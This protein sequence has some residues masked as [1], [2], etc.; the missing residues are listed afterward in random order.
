MTGSGPPV[1][2]RATSRL[3]LALGAAAVVIVVALVAAFLIVRKNP[4][5]AAPPPLSTIRFNGCAPAAADVH[6]TATKVT[7]GDPA[8]PGTTAPTSTAAPGTTSSS[9]SSS[10]STSSSPTSSPSSST[11]SSTS[12]T[13]STTP[14]GSAP[15]TTATIIGRTTTTFRPG[16]ITTP[17]GAE[18]VPLQP[19]AATRAATSD[20]AAAAI[21]RLA[22]PSAQ[23]VDVPLT[24]TGTTATFRIPDVDP[25]AAYT[26]A[27]QATGPCKGAI[28]RMH[29]GVAPNLGGTTF[30]K[31]AGNGMV[32]GGL[33]FA[34]DVDMTARA[35]VYAGAVDPIVLDG[36][37]RDNWRLMDT[38]PVKS[39]RTFHWASGASGT[40]KGRWQLSTAPMTKA[41]DAPSGLLAEGDAPFAA[42][43]LTDQKVDSDFKIDLDPYTQD[44]WDNV[45]DPEF[46]LNDPFN[47]GKGGS[48]TPTPTLPNGMPD[49]SKATGDPHPH[50]F[51]GTFY[52][53]V[54]PLKGD[55]TAD[56]AG[57]ASDQVTLLVGYPSAGQ[58]GQTALQVYAGASN[59]IGSADG[60]NVYYDSWVTADD[61]V[62]WDGTDS[63]SR[64]FR[65][66][67][68][69]PGTTT[70]EWQLSSQP[71]PIDCLDSPN[72]LAT[73]VAPFTPGPFPEKPAAMATFSIDF[74]TMAAD[75]AGKGTPMDVNIPYWLRV[76][77]HG[78]DPKT[79]TGDPSLAVRI[80][81]SNAPAPQY[82]PDNTPLPAPPSAPI[83]VKIASYQPF[84]DLNYN[85]GADQPFCFVALDAHDVS[86]DESFEGLLKVATEDAVG[87]FAVHGGHPS[88]HFQ[89]GEAFC[90][91][92]QPPEPSWWEEAFDFLV[93]VISF[94][95]KVYNL[96]L[97]IIP[98]ILGEILT[99]LGIP[100]SSGNAVNQSVPGGGN[101]NSGG[102]PSDC[103]KGLLFAE[104]AFLSAAGLPPSLPDA[105]QMLDDGEDYMVAE[106]AEN[107]GVDPGKAREA[108][109]QG[110]SAIKQQMAQKSAAQSG[111]TCS[112][113]ATD[114]GSRQPK[115]R[116]ELSRPADDQSGLPTP[117]RLCVRN[118]NP[119]DHVVYAP[120]C[121]WI[122]QL[123]PGQMVTVPIQL[124]PEFGSELKKARSNAY[125]DCYEGL[126]IS[127]HYAGCDDYA[128][129][130]MFQAWQGQH[131][132][133]EPTVAFLAETK[134]EYQKYPNGQ[135][136]SGAGNGSDYHTFDTT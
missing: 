6:L 23:P 66:T 26:V 17:P 54:L 105:Q 79:C 13:S 113:C 39:Q 7:F 34:I 22:T 44:V 83:S 64:M 76:V 28:V 68:T 30:A 128:D 109:D 90:F 3:P 103:F 120:S 67:S 101:D 78:D 96:Y 136:G 10:S 55:G 11:S 134:I 127:P 129:T 31:H 102:E 122:P 8:T 43:A 95:S 97:Q 104:K 27:L 38:V 108:W 118:A 2:A 21:A 56:C 58:T 100:C 20:E 114:N 131:F 106:I 12:T 72:L 98:A 125:S 61:H 29:A 45:V 74:K 57:P 107:A 50:P 89:Q 14:P 81:H 59:Y 135:T 121:V 33:P 32:I 119:P 42:G 112:W 15:S 60:P 53:R 77:P 19:I 82:L 94:P 62:M 110:K 80:K 69:A 49:L 124:A 71:F 51:E 35:E 70:G 73:G 130:T 16:I 86:S 115:L 9:S 5:A 88:H 87:F 41:C 84:H 117:N 24:L 123:K 36:K 47:K 132:G 40:T 37:V 25:T 18:V 1:P 91:T 48:S 99:S 111:W 75:L 52:V 133:K 46:Q 93:D 4:E 63:T 126:P 65:W 116:I 92:V 85:T